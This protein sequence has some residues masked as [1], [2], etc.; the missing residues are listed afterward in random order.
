MINNAH[1]QG[2]PCGE[3]PYS[4][5]F[6]RLFLLAAENST[7]AV[8]V[9]LEENDKVLDWEL[10]GLEGESEDKLASIKHITPQPSS[11]VLYTPKPEAVEEMYEFSALP[12]EFQQLAREA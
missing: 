4:V 7:I 5:F 3:T 11:L 1:C 12:E 10:E 6:G 8:Y 2:L 9:P